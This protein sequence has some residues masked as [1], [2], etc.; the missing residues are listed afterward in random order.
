MRL[1]AA[2]LLVAA[3]LVLPNASAATQS[4]V[5][6]STPNDASL[7]SLANATTYPITLSIQLTTPTCLNDGTATVKL[8]VTSSGNVTSTL[9][10]TTVTFTV[11]ATL[12]VG[13]VPTAQDY[14]GQKQLNL[15]LTPTGPGEGV[16]NVV[17]KFDGTVDGCNAPPDPS[18]P[19]STN[20]APS[21]K[22][23][24]VTSTSIAAPPTNTTTNTTTTPVSSTPASSTP[25]SSSP[26]G[27]TVGEPTP[28]TSTS[29][30]GKK[31]LPGPELG[32][33]VAGV[34]AIAVLARRKK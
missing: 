6:L 30:E 1:L 15:T 14:S 33:V 10:K 27:T 20:Y 7:S 21:M 34:A 8:T 28:T 26:V 5:S 23:I 31:G 9:D 19:G 25:V 2:G 22:S 3:L 24:N 18:D 12:V 32:L 4:T 17:A 11:P 16:T 29:E 13:S